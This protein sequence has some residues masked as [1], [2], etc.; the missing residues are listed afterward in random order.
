MV[1]HTSYLSLTRFA[2]VLGAGLQTWSVWRIY[3]SSA[4]SAIAVYPISLV[5][6]NAFLALIIGGGLFLLISFPIMAWTRALTKNDVSAL[7]DQ[8]KDVRLM[9]PVLDIIGKYHNIFA[10]MVPEKA[11]S[12]EKKE[13]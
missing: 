10:R 4:L 12:D 5:V 9:R 2:G 7:Q 11:R 6:S 3:L 13:T 8:F 1:R